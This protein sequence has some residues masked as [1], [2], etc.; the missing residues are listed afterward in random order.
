VV[1]DDELILRFITAVLSSLGYRT[2]TAT[3]GAAA[4]KALQA[5]SY[6]LLVTDNLMPKV[7]GLE[8]VKQ[9]RSARMTLPII[10]VSG[11][12]P[13]EELERNEWLQPVATLAKPFK[14]DE[15]LGTVKLV[16]RESTIPRE[17]NE[18]LP[19][20][21]QGEFGNRAH[22]VSAHGIL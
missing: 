14:G 5:K 10:M 21:R 4:W 22:V 18:A 17:Q 3:D 16:L 1:D 13:T 6:D 11:S 9:V 19:I 20:F 12:L 7:T 2:K 15:L 8:L